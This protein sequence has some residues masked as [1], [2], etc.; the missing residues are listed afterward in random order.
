MKKGTIWKVIAFVVVLLLLLWFSRSYLSFTPL[1]IR[2]WILSF[3][4][5]APALFVAVYSVRPIV[6]FPASVLSLAGGLAFGTFW[7]F[8]YIFLGALG[9]ATVAYYISAIFQNS[10]IKIEQSERTLTIRK[11]MEESGFFI[12]LILRF[13]PFLNYDL[14]SYLAGLASVKYRSFIFAT[15]LGIIPGTLAFSF[16]GSS[17]VSGSKTIIVFAI[18]VFMI[19]L[20]I[21]IFARNKVKTLL[22]L[23]TN[24][25]K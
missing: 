3:G 21:P 8:V 24:R 5:I 4:W 10:F 2:D 11:K 14:I 15:A 1:E 7:G 25:P 9:S 13:I 18:G 16:L 20:L 6:L 19:V 23:S 12:V 22:G 17:I